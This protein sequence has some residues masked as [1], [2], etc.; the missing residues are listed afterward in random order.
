LW[1]RAGA[2]G[3]LTACRGRKCDLYGCLGVGEGCGDEG[4]LGAGLD[5]HVDNDGEDL[6]WMTSWGV[7]K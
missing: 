1:D 6:F 3:V 5:R 2:D 7:R 4:V